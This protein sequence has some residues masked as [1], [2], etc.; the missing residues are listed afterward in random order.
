MTG[1]VWHCVPWLGGS[2][3]PTFCQ[4]AACSYRIGHQCVGVHACEWALPPLT[5]IWGFT[6]SLFDFNRHDQF[7]LQP[8]EPQSR[9]LCNCCMVAPLQLAFH[10]FHA[11]GLS[12]GRGSY[13]GFSGA[14]TELNIC[15]QPAPRQRLALSGDLY[16]RP[17]SGRDGGA[18]RSCGG[19][20]E[21]QT[22]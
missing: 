1:I 7:Q 15:V 9:W 19:I 3:S 20:T 5:P 13:E 16:N 17:A 2:D 4:R 12:R 21:L 14:C 8:N 18:C 11:Q 22:D 6:S 10:R